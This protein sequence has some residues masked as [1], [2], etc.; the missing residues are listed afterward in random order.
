[1]SCSRLAVI[2]RADNVA[3]L[4]SALKHDIPPFLPFGV[5]AEIGENNANESLDHGFNIILVF[6][7]STLSIL[8]ALLPQCITTIKRIAS[9]LCERV[10][11]SN[12]LFVGT[13]T[14]APCLN[15]DTGGIRHL[16]AWKFKT[17]TPKEVI[18]VAVEGYRALPRE[19]PYFLHLETGAVQVGSDY[20]FALFSTFAG[21]EEQ[22]NFVNDTR[23]K[24]F[25]ARFVQPY[26]ENDGV[27][28]LDYCPEML[29][30]RSVL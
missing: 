23:R 22:T 25:K 28:V 20:T 30:I 1:M 29:S 17:D 10:S 7:C 9:Q 18:A 11:I 15:R 3:P 26:L 5:A 4:L 27:L 13:P 24:S 2:I 12:F 8:S 21:T 19:L 16:V 6:S 14:E